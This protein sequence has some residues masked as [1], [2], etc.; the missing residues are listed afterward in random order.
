MKLVTQLSKKLTITYGKGWLPQ[1][2]FYMK[3]FYQNYPQLLAKSEILHAESGDSC[4]PGM[5]L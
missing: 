2:L 5:F 3:Q 1:N 4:L